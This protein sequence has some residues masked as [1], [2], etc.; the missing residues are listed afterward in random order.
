MRSEFQCAG[1]RYGDDYDNGEFKKIETWIQDTLLPKVSRSFKERAVDFAVA[2]WDYTDS[3]LDSKE[4]LRL[5]DW[6]K[7]KFLAQVAH[8]QL[9]A[10]A[11]VTLVQP[12]TYGVSTWDSTEFKRFED[13]VFSTLL[14]GLQKVF[15]AMDSAHATV[16]G[17]D[18]TDMTSFATVAQMRELEQRLHALEVLVSQRQG[19]R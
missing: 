16:V 1:W 3:S 6:F 9:A 11:G 10:G 8:A 15:I 2:R 12:W 14:P 5:Q 7:D 18:R 17:R 13:W 4:F 19:P